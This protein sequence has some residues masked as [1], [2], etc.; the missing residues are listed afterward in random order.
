MTDEPPTTPNGHRQAPSQ[1]P[2]RRFDLLRQANAAWDP[3]DNGGDDAV[4]RLHLDMRPGP[5]AATE[6]RHALDRLDGSVDEAQLD[7]LRLLVSEVVTNSV[8]H[9][10][11]G[12]EW[13]QLD[14]GI[15]ANAVH[16]EVHDRGPGFHPEGPPRPHADRPGGWG[17][18]LVDRLSRRWGVATDDRT[19]VWFEID[20]GN[21]RDLASAA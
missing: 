9:G 7:T 5:Q 19:R 12:D 8:R 4:A 6:A 18:C 17:L 2:F 1:R 14:V 3:V 10:G 15:H 11:G 16:V 21:R 20:R 13:I